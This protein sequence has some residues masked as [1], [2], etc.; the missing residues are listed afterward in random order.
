MT[1]GQ[2]P[3]LLPI[4]L[5]KSLAPAADTWS[6]RPRTQSGCI[7]RAPLR[8][9]WSQVCFARPGCALNRPTWSPVKG[10]SARV[11]PIR[12]GIVVRQRFFWIRNRHRH[13]LSATLLDGRAGNGW[14][15][16][17]RCGRDRSGGGF[18][19]AGYEPHLSYGDCPLAAS[20]P[21]K[22]SG[23][24]IPKNCCRTTIAERMVETPVELPCI[25]D[26]V[27]CLSHDQ[28][29]GQRAEEGGAADDRITGSFGK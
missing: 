18:P 26:Q 24:N 11:S 19:N 12:S 16:L 1:P 5:M 21:A 7:G 2:S 4:C 23:Q 29:A 8:L 22:K 28:A 9:C 13:H 25:G 27:V 10:S 14:A 20:E 15:R 17:S 3:W 6:R